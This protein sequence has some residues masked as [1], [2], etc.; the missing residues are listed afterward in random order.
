MGAREIDAGASGSEVDGQARTSPFPLDENI[1]PI[2][3]RPRDVED[4][5]AGGDLLPE[6]LDAGVEKS[7]LHGSGVV[8][9]DAGDDGRQGKSDPTH[10]GPPIATPRGCDAAVNDLYP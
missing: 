8:P 7:R 3:S 1:D 9:G 6:R 5:R 4:L 2:L 10:S